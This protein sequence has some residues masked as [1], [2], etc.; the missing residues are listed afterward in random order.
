MGAIVCSAADTSALEKET[1]L[2]TRA[3]KTRNFFENANRNGKNRLQDLSADAIDI[4]AD[5][6]EKDNC[7]V[8]SVGFGKIVHERIY[9]SQEAPSAPLIVEVGNHLRLHPTQKD[10]NSNGWIKR[11]KADVKLERNH[12]KKPYH[13]WTA[14]TWNCF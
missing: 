4:T 1:I 6:E 7:R 3:N 2:N 14:I 8:L 12:P 11:S 10:F 13:N 5:C 9:L